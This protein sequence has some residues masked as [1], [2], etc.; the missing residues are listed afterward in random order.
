[1]RIYED[2]LD[3]LD[4]RHVD[5]VRLV[6]SRRQLSCLF[7]I[8]QQK[9]GRFNLHMKDYDTDVHRQVVEHDV[10]VYT[11]MEVSSLE[12]VFNMLH[13]VHDF[14]ITIEQYDDYQ[15]TKRERE[16]TVDEFIG[17]AGAAWWNAMD[18]YDTPILAYRVYVDVNESTTPDEFISDF[19]TIYKKVKFRYG[20]FVI[21]NAEGRLPEVLYRSGELDFIDYDNDIIAAYDAIFNTNYEEE[22]HERYY[23]KDTFSQ[24]YKRQYKYLSSFV[25]YL[26]YFQKKNADDESSLYK[27]EVKGLLN[28]WSQF[29]SDRDYTLLI[30]IVPKDND[31]NPLRMKEFVIRNII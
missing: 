10:R 27:F 16:W 15:M 17:G 14:R 6:D 30:D 26:M 19:Y 7:L 4:D 21:K 20:S 8:E 25:R 31:Y 24:Q 13:F 29:Q 11:S 18:Y 28:D 9:C 23:K 12:T 22:Y 1:M 3:S 5:T 2:F